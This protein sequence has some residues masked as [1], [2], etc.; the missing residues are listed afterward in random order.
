LDYAARFDSLGTAA[1]YFNSYHALAIVVVISLLTGL[2]W[3]VFNFMNTNLEEKAR[4]EELIEGLEDMEKD[5]KAQLKA[6]EK[7]KQAM[8]TL[9]T[10]GDRKEDD[11]LIPVDINKNLFKSFTDTL[12]PSE[13]TV[14]STK[15]L[16]DGKENKEEN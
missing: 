8:G 13:S 12:S 7:N 11:P 10:E 5:I 16:K 2:V 14:E 9:N 4:V 1:L 15:D 3:E 6:A